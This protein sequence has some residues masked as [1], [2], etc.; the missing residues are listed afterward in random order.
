MRTPVDLVAGNLRVVRFNGLRLRIFGLLQSFGRNA[1]P[2]AGQDV[3]RVDLLP[4]S[5]PRLT[6]VGGV[7]SALDALFFSFHGRELAR[8]CVW[9]G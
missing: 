8:L 7:D 4:R 1:E 5:V 6:A 9:P 3:V 2:V